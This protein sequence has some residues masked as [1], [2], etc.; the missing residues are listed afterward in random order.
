MVFDPFTV[1]IIKDK[2][3]KSNRKKQKVLCKRFHIFLWVCKRLHKGGGEYEFFFELDEKSGRAGSQNTVCLIFKL[4]CLIFKL[5]L[6][7]TIN[8]KLA[9]YPITPYTNIIN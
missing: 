6:L 5:I 3:Q 2:N 8:S 4:Q 9:F 7:S 1:T